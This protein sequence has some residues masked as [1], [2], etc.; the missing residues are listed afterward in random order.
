MGGRDSPDMARED[1][2]SCHSGSRNGSRMR[3][4]SLLLERKVGAEKGKDKSGSVVDV[5]RRKGHR[6]WT[7]SPSEEKGGE[8]K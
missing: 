8:R 4:R 7:P 2:E 1:L 5:A 3:G 6:K